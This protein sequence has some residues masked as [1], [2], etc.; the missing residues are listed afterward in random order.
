MTRRKSA[1]TDTTTRVTIDLRAD[2]DLL[3]E[4]LAERVADY[5]VYVNEG[6]G[7][8]AD[9]VALITFGYQ[10]DQAGWA[11]LVLDTR[12]DASSDGSWQSHIEPNAVA[13]RHW[14]RAFRAA[15]SGKPVAV[16]RPGGRRKTVRDGESLVACVGEMLR[17]LLVAAEADG[18]FA[19][20]PR[21]AEV[22]LA[23][24]DHDGAWGWPEADDAH[25]DDA[26]L[27]EL[28]RKA[29]RLSK[30]KQLALWIAELEAI[31]SN[32]SRWAWPSLVLE[33]LLARVLALGTPGAVALLEI[34]LRWAKVNEFVPDPEGPR[35]A[36]IDAPHQGVVIDSIWAVRDHG[37]ATPEIERLLQRSI[38]AACRASVDERRE[39]WGST[40][41]QA[42]DCLH[43]LFPGYPEPERDDETNALREWASFTRR[44]R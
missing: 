13:L 36:L 8:D 15:T 22:A 31:A 40:P 37:P 27:E 21:M 16:I 14:A 3:E 32:A 7:K 23:V 39:P 18:V 25:H 1:T 30:R 33:K 34:V 43:R 38:R 41:Y 9:P 17:D 10:L 11:A 20:L 44:P 24:E 42:A 26:E 4:H 6:P 19:A 5:P 12:R 29:R 28:D 2:R 35:G